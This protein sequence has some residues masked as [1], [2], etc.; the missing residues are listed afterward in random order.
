MSKFR[1]TAGE[2]VDANLAPSL[3]SQAAE[4]NLSVSQF[5]NRTYPT[6]ATKYGTAFDQMLASSGLVVPSSA[7][8]SMYGVRPPNMRDVLE[9]RASMMG[10]AG[11]QAAST[12]AGVGSTAGGSQSRTLFPA[13]LIAYMETAL[14]KDYDT[15]LNQFNQMIAQDISVNNE[16]FEQPLIN[17]NTVGGPMQSRAQRRAQLAGPS[18]MLSFT[19]A[20]KIRRIPTYAIG[21]EFSNEA[22]RASTLDLVGLS[23]RRYM[24][25]EQDSWVN[26]YLSDVYAGDLDINSGSLASLGYSVATVTLDPA[27]PAGKITQTAWLKWLWRNRKYRKIDWVACDLA[28]YLLIE[29]RV[30]RPS[31][32]AIDTS[33]PRLDAQAT[34]QNNGIGDVKVFIVD[35][36]ALGG[37][38]PAGT[39]MGIDSRYAMARVR[40]T[41]ADV[42]ASEKYALRQAEAF[43]LQ[44]GEIVYRMH[45]DAF[46]VLTVS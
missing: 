32:T 41:S 14:V 30:G 40:N 45:D 5:I 43:S 46:D 42:K 26:S 3:Y 39:I 27:C 36:A 13:A 19:T 33:I 29:A 18:S 2:L 9:G 31:L 11:F 34:V 6:D 23:L 24:S 44:F 21:M 16:T 1:N 20:D 8:Q 4:A 22:L 35:D 17:M 28:T 12:T 15:D 25:V 38:L 7:A 37:P 10:G